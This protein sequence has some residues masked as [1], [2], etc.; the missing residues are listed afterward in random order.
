MDYI[1]RESQ[2]NLLQIINEEIDQE[3]ADRAKKIADE[4]VKRIPAKY[5]FMKEA[6]QKALETK[7]PPDE[8]IRLLPSELKNQL[9]GYFQW[10]QQET[11]NT[12]EDVISFIK[13]TKTF[14][15]QNIKKGKPS[16]NP[17]VSEQRREPL[18]YNGYY[19]STMLATGGP[20]GTWIPAGGPLLRFA[21]SATW[22]FIK[23][24]IWLATIYFM[25]RMIYTYIY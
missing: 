6:Y 2:L 8:F 1:I 21:E 19:I 5:N 24:L 17:E 22:D 12:S 4:I 11:S 20:Y 9:K 25:L 14:L 23:L 3:R 10:L 15:Q 13:K 18:Y 7:N 16:S